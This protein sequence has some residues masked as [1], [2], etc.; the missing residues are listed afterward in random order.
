MFSPLHIKETSLAR[1]SGTSNDGREAGTENV[2]SLQDTLHTVTFY[3]FKGGVGRTLALLNVAY[4]LAEQGNRV[5]IADFDLEAPGIDAYPGFEPPRSSQP[6]LLEYMAEYVDGYGGKAPEV[7]RYV[8][9]AKVY[10]PSDEYDPSYEENDEYD[11]AEHGALFVIRAGRQDDTYRR[12]L[13]RQDWDKLFT[14]LD[15][16]MFFANMKGELFEKFGCSFLLLDS[17]TGLTD[18]AGLCTAYLPDAVVLMFY[19][20]QQNIRGTEIVARAIKRFEKSD[21]RVIPVIPRMYCVSRV[22]QQRDRLDNAPRE[23][24][25]L[26]NRVE[27]KI[28]VSRRDGWGWRTY[29][30]AAS[31]PDGGFARRVRSMG[32]RMTRKGFEHDLTDQSRSGFWGFGGPALCTISEQPVRKD[33]IVAVTHQTN[34]PYVEPYS[35]LAAFASFGNRFERQQLRS[36]VKEGETKD[37][38]VIPENIFTGDKIADRYMERWHWDLR[39]LNS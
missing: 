25:E 9:P 29:K 24:R 7:S 28:E 35:K 27:G 1:K 12:R 3:S 17:R 37:E 11:D 14:Q 38:N 19:P 6:G 39:Y 30:Y 15:G 34:H 8:Y 16:Q 32:S 31:E 4:F 23:A 2:R 22:P 33:E 10:K 20:D 26:R 36:L 18:V 21:D 5:A 13:A